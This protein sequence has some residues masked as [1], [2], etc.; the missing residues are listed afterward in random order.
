MLFII[1]KPEQNWP[2][3]S[4]E[5][6][7]AVTAPDKLSTTDNNNEPKYVSAPD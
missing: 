5:I 2:W 4:I 1:Q 3:L 6:V 7:F